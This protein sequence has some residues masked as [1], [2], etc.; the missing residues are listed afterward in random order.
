MQRL[1]IPVSQHLRLQR[2]ETGKALGNQ[3]SG[4]VATTQDIG[5]IKQ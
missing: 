1:W 4:M 5:R 2:N 3:A